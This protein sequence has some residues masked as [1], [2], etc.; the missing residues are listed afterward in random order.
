[1]MVL[2]DEAKKIVKQSMLP[3]NVALRDDALAAAAASIG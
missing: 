3:R 2:C 1:M